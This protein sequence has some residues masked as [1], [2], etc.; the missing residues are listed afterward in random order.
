MI[1]SRIS[2]DKAKPLTAAGCAGKL[3]P[4][5]TG[6]WAKSAVMRSWISGISEALMGGGSVC[7][8]SAEKVLVA[9]GLA[10]FPASIGGCGTVGAR[11]VVPDRGAPVAGLWRRSRGTDWMT[12]AV[13]RVPATITVGAGSALSP[14]I[15]ALPRMAGSWAPPADVASV[16]P[17]ALLGPVKPCAGAPD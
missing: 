15:W 17:S 9:L 16:W 6:G 8:K 2:G 4:A 7:K 11:D 3:A 1:R 5:S 10:A 14:A 12:I 13:K